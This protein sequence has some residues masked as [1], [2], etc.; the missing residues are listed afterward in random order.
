[1]DNWACP[2]N[3]SRKD[4]GRVKNNR[5]KKQNEMKG[6]TC[7]YVSIW[8]NC[9]FSPKTKNVSLTLCQNIVNTCNYTANQNTR[10][11]YWTTYCIFLCFSMQ[12]FIK[13]GVNLIPKSIYMTGECELKKHWYFQIRSRNW[14]LPSN[15][16]LQ[17]PPFSLSISECEKGLNS[18]FLWTTSPYMVIPLFIFFPIPQF[19]Q[20]FSVN[21]APLKYRINTKINSGV[22]II[23]LF[24]ED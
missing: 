3:N 11:V 19:W 13:L 17:G 23:S 10:P 16:G 5:L 2:V 12:R 18:P 22:R 9:S 6:F 20:D 24:L 8:S 7:T 1:M 4:T 15:S 21:I 14:S